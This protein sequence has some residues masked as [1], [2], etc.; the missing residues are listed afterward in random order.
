MIPDPS[1]PRWKRVLV[2][3]GDV[4][5]ASL[6]TRILLTRLRGDVK[7]TPASLPAKIDELRAFMVKNTFAQADAAL[8]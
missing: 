3:D 4:S 1:D 6:A 8:F 7:R 2:S 5:R